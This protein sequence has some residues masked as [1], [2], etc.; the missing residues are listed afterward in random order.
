MRDALLLPNSGSFIFF[1]KKYDKYKKHRKNEQVSDDGVGMDEEKAA[2]LLSSDHP[3]YGVY[4]VNDRLVLN[5][6]QSARLVYHSI[7][8]EGTTVTVRLPFQIQ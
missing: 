3:G 8:G 5:Y 2:Q 7:P 1:I 6:G 4:N